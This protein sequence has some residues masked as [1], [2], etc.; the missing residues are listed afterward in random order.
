MMSDGKPIR[1]LVI[2]G[3]VPR[4]G[5]V[6]A[7][8]QADPDF[9]IVAWVG[10]GPEAIKTVASL[11]PQVIVIELAH[12]PSD[13]VA[14]ARCI[15]EETPTP[16]VMVTPSPGAEHSPRPSAVADAGVLVVLDK[17]GAGAARKA[18]ED[19]LRT[20]KSMST[21][22]VIRRWGTGKLKSPAT[23]LGP[24]M[25]MPPRSFQVVAIGASTGGPQALHEI[26]TSLPATF[27]LPVLVVQHIAPGFVDSMI[28][29]LRPLCQLPIQRAV[30]G[31]PLTV[32]GIYLAPTDHHLVVH[33]G[34]VGLTHDPLVSGHRPAATVLFRTIA[35][36]YGKTAIGVLLTGMGDDGAVGL[37]AIKQ[38]GGATIAQSESSS[39]VFGMPAAAIGLG[40][41]DYI[42]APQEIAGLLLKLAGPVKET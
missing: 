14:T 5:H 19:L 15:M 30:A 40:I 24:L 10:C 21:V 9:E 7:L 38:A 17:P 12:P 22:K 1:A 3:S 20:I 23:A 27:Q 6:L 28:D 39:V 2:E 29:W 25:A 34:L 31:M 13:E 37:A 42:L 16:I 4:Q 8:L 36:S 26:L 18:T 35:T 32:P 41:V 33:N 11:K